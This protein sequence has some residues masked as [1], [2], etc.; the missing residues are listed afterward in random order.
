MFAQKRIL[1]HSKC[2]H[3]KPGMVRCG[4]VPRDSHFICYSIDFSA[5]RLYEEQ[6]IE[7]RR[8]YLHLP[9]FV[10]NLSG[11]MCGLVV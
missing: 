3:I 5:F 1:M 11:L 7:V 2:I 8:Y 4:V 6:L 9:V 10:V